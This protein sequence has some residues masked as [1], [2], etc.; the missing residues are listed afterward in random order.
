MNKNNLIFEELTISDEVVEVGNELMKDIVNGINKDN[1]YRVFSTLSV[2]THLVKSYEN[3]LIK[4]IFGLIKEIKI[5]IYFFENKEDFI[6]SY[7]HFDYGGSL[8]GNKTIVLIGYGYAN[9]I[10]YDF[11]SSLLYHELKHAYQESLFT[12]TKELPKILQTATNII[13]GNIET[14]DRGIYE[15]SKLLYYFNRNEINANM[16]SLYQYLMNNKPKSLNDY[17]CPTL[18]EYKHYKKL[19]DSS[20]IYI[21][22][23]DVCTKLQHLYGKTFQQLMRLIQFGIGYFETKERKV[24][25]KYF[26]DQRR[27]LHEKIN[28]TKRFFM[29]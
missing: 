25:A 1:G 10:R 15:I 21:A 12:N 18:Q 2:P 27:I 4:P 29:R 9:R 3:S 24:F 22:D 11:L 20:Q 16:E 28:F 23:N 13:C 7:N 6:N 26:I 17:K 14:H 5:I 8:I 19:Y